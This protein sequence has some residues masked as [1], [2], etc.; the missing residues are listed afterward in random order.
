MIAASLESE[1]V[2][3]HRWFGLGRAQRL[4]LR[5][6]ITRTGAGIAGWVGE[7]EHRKRASGA[8]RTGAGTRD[9]GRGMGDGRTRSVHV[10]P[11]LPS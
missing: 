6:V 2:S 8:T 1:E 10:D 3:E 4:F 7:R 9:G 5:V 11:P